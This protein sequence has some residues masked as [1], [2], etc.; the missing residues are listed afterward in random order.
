MKLKDREHVQGTENPSVYIGRRVKPDG[1]VSRRWSAVYY[2]GKRQVIKSLRTRFKHE[3]FKAA[4]EL[5]R[6]LVRG[7]CTA[8][9]VVITV[10]ELVKEYLDMLVARGRSHKTSTKYTRVLEDFA[11][12]CEKGLQWKRA[13]SAKSSSGGTVS[14]PSSRS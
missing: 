8:A 9:P 3:A 12:V 5:H 10:A 13:K 6:A 2:D 14:G 4:Q 7:D 1:T 11:G